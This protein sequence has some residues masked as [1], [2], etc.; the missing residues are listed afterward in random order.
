MKLRVQYT[1]QLRT[2][3]GRAEDEVELPE[4]TTLA[5]L[6]RHLAARPDGAASHLIAADGQAHHSLLI[7]VN[8]RAVTSQD[9]A[10]TLLQPGD[11]VAL[12]PP[13]AGG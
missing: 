8:D 9:A 2:A 4:G 13:I 11:V 10:G 12:L 5:A 6:V 1:A 3:T 7:V